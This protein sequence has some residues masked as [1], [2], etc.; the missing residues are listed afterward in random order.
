MGPLVN[1]RCLT[2]SKCLPT[3]LR[4]VFGYGVTEPSRLMARKESLKEMKNKQ[5]KEMS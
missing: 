1:S 4:A 3:A 5:A 2:D